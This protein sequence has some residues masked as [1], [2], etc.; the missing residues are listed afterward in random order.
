MPITSAEGQVLDVLCLSPREGKAGAL[1]GGVESPDPGASA[2]IEDTMGILDGGEG[3]FSTG[4]EE[5]D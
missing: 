4:G 3:E 2:D 1:L 5:T